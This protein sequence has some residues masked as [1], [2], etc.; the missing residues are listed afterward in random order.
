[1]NKKM[2]RLAFAVWCPVL[3]A[4]A[5]GVGLATAPVESSMLA[6]AI[7]PAP[8]AIRPIAARLV[9]GGNSRVEVEVKS[10]MA[11]SIRLQALRQL[12]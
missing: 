4:S 10:V 9:N 3:P 8:P 1:M 5:L 6:S 2:T 11:A 12:A 7:A